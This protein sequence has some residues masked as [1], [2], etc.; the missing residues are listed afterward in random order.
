M[1]RT[2]AFTIPLLS[3]SLT[4]QP[5]PEREDARFRAGCVSRLCQPLR[6]AA[7]GSGVPRRRGRW[8]PAAWN[9]G[10]GTVNR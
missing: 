9:A 3:I 6:R 1:R 4:A 10:D 8:R 2:P 5:L 7:L